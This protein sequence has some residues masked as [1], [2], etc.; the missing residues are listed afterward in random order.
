MPMESAFALDGKRGAM[1]IMRAFH[2]LVPKDCRDDGRRAPMIR[3][4]GD[5]G[6]AASAARS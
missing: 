5:A 6:A 4:A 3:H 2:W 1:A